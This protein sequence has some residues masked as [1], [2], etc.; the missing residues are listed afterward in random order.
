MFC[1]EANLFEAN[2]NEERPECRRKAAEEEETW[3]AAQRREEEEQRRVLQ[4]ERRRMLA[5]HVERLVGHIPKG[6]LNQ[7]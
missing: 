4:E 1:F 6:V 2:Q 5:Q 7:V 3:W